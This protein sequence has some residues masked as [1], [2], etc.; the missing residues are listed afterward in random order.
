MIDAEIT[1]RLAVMA[2]L[3]D[4][5]MS[6]E[7]KRGLVAVLSRY[8]AKAVLAALDRCLIEVPKF[9]TLADIVSRIDDGRPGIEEAWSMLP[10]S[11]GDSVVWTDEMAEAYGVVRKQLETDPVGARM[12]FKEVYGKLL[13]EA[14]TSGGPVNFWASWGS[15]QEKRLLVER[16]AQEKGRLALPPAEAPLMLEGPEEADPEAVREIV[17]SALK[18]IPAEEKRVIAE[19]AQ[20]AQ[21]LTPEQIEERKREL[22]AQAKVLGSDAS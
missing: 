8:P 22:R 3:H 16:E 15:D 14:R 1:K 19:K 2:E 21:E 7:A 11:E 4:K 10:R 18:G 5:A 13:G 9:P 6:N 20:A 17:R 12:A